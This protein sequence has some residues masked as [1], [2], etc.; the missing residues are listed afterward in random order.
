MIS[1]GKPPFDPKVFLSKVNGGRAISDYRKD[2][3]VYRQGEA[4]DSVF[5]VQSG[6][7]KATV[8]SEQGKEAVVAVL[9]ID[10]FFGEG[11][12]AGQPLRLSTVS[13]MT[14]CVIVRRH[15]PRHPRRAS[16]CRVIYLAPLGPQQSCRGGLGRST[17]QF[18]RET[19]GTDPSASGEFR[20]RRSAGS[21][22]SENQPRD[23]G[24]DDRHDAISCEPFHEQIS[25]IGPY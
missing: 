15:H 19:A 14:Q 4:A 16:I 12:L 1:N 25:G 10:D 18:K 24:G 3:I 22:Y 20:Q 7:V 9:G 11:C 17:V 6:K 5:Y 8:V 2:Q 23:T 21:N 13:A